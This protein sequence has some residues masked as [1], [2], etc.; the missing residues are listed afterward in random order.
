VENHNYKVDHGVIRL[1]YDLD[2]CQTGLEMGETALLTHTG[3]SPTT[4]IV[5]P[6][7]VKEA[8]QVLATLQKNWTVV[9]VPGLDDCG[10]MLLNTK[11]VLI[12]PFG[13]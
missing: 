1:P 5:S 10:W 13:A 3:I 11:G 8:Y 7:L 2:L 12:S 9:V 6:F 4:L